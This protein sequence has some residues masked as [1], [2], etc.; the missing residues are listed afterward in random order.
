MNAQTIW[1]KNP[2]AIWTGNDQDASGGV[3][4]SNGVITQV[5]AAGQSPL[6]ESTIVF[7]ASEH[8]ILPGLIN[9]HHHFYQTLTRA[10]PTALNKNL[11]PWLKSLYQVW[12][13]LSPEMLEVATELALTELLLSGCTTAADHHYLFPDG[14]ENAI[15]I[16]AQV[17]EKMDTRIHEP[18][19]SRWRPATTEYRTTGRRHS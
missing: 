17:A 14:L 5:L 4:V 6:D 1:I 13:N 11:F 8:V 12:A 19:G 16:Q 10:Y 7:D 9:T 2:L 18:R 15:D 3:V